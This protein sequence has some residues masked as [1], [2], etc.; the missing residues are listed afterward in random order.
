VHPSTVEEEARIGDF[1]DDRKRGWTRNGRSVSALPK[2][3]VVLPTLN[4]R[5]FITDC[6]E[7]LL[8][9]TYTGIKEILVVDGGSSDD[10]VNIA[11]SRGE[12]ICVLHNSKVTAAAAMN[13][14]LHAAGG[15]IIV[16]ADA[17]SLYARDYVERCVATLLETNADNV[18]G[19]MMPVGITAFGRAVA[20]VT[21][22]PI[23]VGPGR[24][25][26]STSRTDV[27][28]VYL[29]CWWKDTLVEIGGFDAD[30]L[31][32]AAEDHE[33]NFR[34]RQR[35]G[36]IV[37]DPSI[38]S[39]YFPRQSPRALWQ[40]YRNYG[41][42]KA[43]TLA[44]HHSLPSWRP[45]VPAL[46]VFGSSALLLMPGRWFK[47]IA[48]PLTHAMF[49]AVSAAQLAREEGVDVGRT[50]AAL[51]I[52]HWGYGIGALDGLWRIVRGVPFEKI[53]WARQ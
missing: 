24:F 28:T 48:L 2:V 43:S 52:C 30:G 34:L 13:L 3:S 23:G 20:A 44:K 53:P 42:G 50:F 10:T 1:D 35:G 33:L 7:S 29:G 6:L 12:P 22:S 19:R 26:Y 15:E 4:E 18:G 46:L 5:G 8:N 37:L 36:R 11:R 16:R 32:W 41:V 49:C 17:H 31:Q 38:R 40:Q 27:D 9:Q 39:W 21:S 14:G 47:R 25:H 45:V 51:E